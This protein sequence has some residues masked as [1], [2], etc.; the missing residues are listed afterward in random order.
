MEFKIDLDSINIEKM[1]MDSLNNSDEI[2]TV[3]QNMFDEENVKD[4]IKSKVIAYLNSNMFDKCV[5]TSIK[6]YFDDDFDISNE[7]EL[8][9]LISKA[10][11]K[12]IKQ[13]F[14]I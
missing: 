8:M 9:D 2:D 11:I 5:S 7:N 14:N 6:K 10:I 12:N 3:V 1:I 4:A 13:K